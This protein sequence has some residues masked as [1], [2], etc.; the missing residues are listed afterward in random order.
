MTSE[1]LGEMFEGD[2]CRHAHRKISASVD[3]G[4]SGGSSVHRPGSF[5]IN[6]DTF[7]MN[8]DTY[9]ITTFIILGHVHF[10]INLDT[11]I[12]TT[13]VILGHVCFPNSLNLDDT[14]SPINWG[15]HMSSASTIINWDWETIILGHVFSLR[16]LDST[17]SL[18]NRDLD[19]D[20]TSV[21]NNLGHVI[22]LIQWDQGPAIDAFSD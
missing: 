9:T 2:R 8:L 20:I 3:G 17:P 6:L 15:L 18:I 5:I 4:P 12:I 10:F 16:D 19:M 14:S 22:F 1:G 21:C 7:I 11:Y 13:S